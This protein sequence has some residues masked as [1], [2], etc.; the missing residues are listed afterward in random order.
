MTF[1]VGEL[2]GRAAQLKQKAIDMYVQMM[3][4][5]AGEA[6]GT[7]MAYAEDQAKSLF[8]DVDH[9][10]DDFLDCP[11]PEDFVWHVESLGRAMQSLATT[12]YQK[13]PVTGGTT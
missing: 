10:Y 8:G 1:D 11:A 7:V 3:A 12:S 4:M 5:G 13:D 9:I 2:P 6:A